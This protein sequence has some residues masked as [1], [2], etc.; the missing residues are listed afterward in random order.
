MSKFIFENKEN[1]CFCDLSGEDMR[2]AMNSIQELDGHGELQRYCNDEW[3]FSDSFDG[4]ILYEVFRVLAKPYTLEDALSDLGRMQVENNN[5]DIS[6]S[7]VIDT[8]HA[9]QILEKL[10]ASLGDKS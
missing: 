7:M 4:D 9:M 2:H 5:S 8:F 1:T 3:V 10:A 6:A